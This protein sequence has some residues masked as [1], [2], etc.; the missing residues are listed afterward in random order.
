MLKF[1]ILVQGTAQNGC[2]AAVCQFYDILSRV[3]IQF[4][5]IHLPV[6]VS[7]RPVFQSL[8]EIVGEDTC[9]QSVQF[10]ADLVFGACGEDYTAPAGYG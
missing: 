2:L 4:E 10:L 5:N 6:A 3:S 8:H 1:H 9:L 7:I